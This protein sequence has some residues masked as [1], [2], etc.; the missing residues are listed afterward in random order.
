MNLK[1]II[2]YLSTSALLQVLNLVLSFLAIKLLNLSDLGRYNIAKS[3]AGTFQFAN[4]GFR[5]SLDRK[6]PESQN[7]SLNILRLSICA[8]VNTIVSTLILAF[9]AFWYGF[10]WF[11]IL[12]GL[13][14]AF[15]ASFT[16]LRVYYR[17]I[18]QIDLFISA[19][20]Y[21]GVLPIVFPILGLYFF[22]LIGIGVS[23]LLSSILIFF[24]Y[25][26]KVQLFTFKEILA[27]KKYTFIFFKVGSI[28]YL[29]NFFEFI[30]NNFDRFFIEAYSG[31]A[32]VGE[33][34]IIILVFSLSL[35]IPGAILELV[36]TDYIRDKK[37]KLKI[38]KHIK[39]HLKINTALIMIFIVLSYFL[40]PYVI[41]L[42]FSKYTY[43]IYPMQVILLALIPYIFI[44]PIYSVLFAFDRHK[45]I[46]YANLIATIVYFILLYL[47]LSRNYTVLNL[48]YIKIGYTTL[49]LLFMIV[50]LV[51][52]LVSKKISFVEK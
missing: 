50:F 9:F 27:H 34:G 17:G 12:Y 26:R 11:Y 14:G 42:A 7:E 51:H 45:Q 52:G 18:S 5:Y 47:V 1:K 39:K 25:K 30:A 2:K 43:L 10:N 4:L 24:Y 44:S 13:G 40:L 6:L 32:A 49:Y 19:S 22:G 16:L 21:G 48:V 20:L 33:Y 15:I 3:I 37:N 31:L 35:I 29:T 8:Y 23:F 38:L 28:I 41:P 36:F 46:F